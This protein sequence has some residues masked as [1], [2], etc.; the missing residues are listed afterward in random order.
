MSGP[1]SVLLFRRRFVDLTVVLGLSN[2]HRKVVS[3]SSDK[4]IMSSSSNKGVAVKKSGSKAA[5]VGGAP[6]SGA[7]EKNKDKPKKTPPSLRIFLVSPR[8][9]AKIAATASYL[10]PMWRHDPDI[11]FGDD[12]SGA[13]SSLTSH[14]I[15]E[16]CAF[17]RELGD[18][19]AEGECTIVVGS[20]AEGV[21][22]QKLIEAMEGF[23]SDGLYDHNG[24]DDSWSITAESSIC[25]GLVFL[26]NHGYR[27][28]DF[29]GF[30]NSFL[31]FDR[32][33]H[34]QDPRSFRLIE[35]RSAR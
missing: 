28:S 17:L 33:I 34:F 9:Q 35:P 16:A 3:E 6:S 25:E 19:I 1:S 2:W 24:G 18:E 22:F 11:W 4:T 13:H 32:P 7:Q 29:S 5:G 20:D 10:Y 31:D 15:D 14:E 23:E 30:E 8:L 12:E 27:D 26:P 21:A